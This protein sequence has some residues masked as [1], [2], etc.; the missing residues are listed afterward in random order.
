MKLNKFIISALLA[1]GVQFANAAE[2]PILTEDFEN[3]DV[4]TWNWDIVSIASGNDWR[5][6]DWNGSGVAQMSGFNADADSNDWLVS[7]EIE[8]TS[9]NLEFVYVNF[10]NEID[11]SGPATR[12]LLSTDYAGDVTT[13]TW[14]DLSDEVVWSTDDPADSGKINLTDYVGQNIYLAFHYTS[15]PT[16]A[17]RISI[18]NLNVI[19]TDEDPAVVTEYLETFSGS[20]GEWT[21][22]SLSGESVWEARSFSGNGFAQMSGFGDDDFSNDWLVSPEFDVTDWE[23]PY[24]QFSTAK[25][26]DGDAL[27]VFVTTNYNAEGVEATDWVEITDSFAYSEGGYDSVESGRLDLRSIIGDEDAIRVAFQYTSSEA[28]SALWQVDN[29]LVGRFNPAV[30]LEVNT[31][32]EPHF[33]GLNDGFELWQSVNLSGSRSWEEN[34]RFDGALYTRMSG[35]RDDADSI[36]WLVS[37]TFDMSNWASQTIEFWSATRFDGPVIQVLVSTDFVDNVETATWTDI[38]EQAALSEGDYNWVNS[39]VIDVSDMVTSNATFAF[40]YT[41]DDSGAATWQLDSLNVGGVVPVRP[42]EFTYTT[43]SLEEFSAGFT[44]WS[45]VS[46][47]SDRDWEAGVAVD[48]DY[49]SISGDGGDV[50][51]NDWLVSPTIDTTANDWDTA[52]VQLATAKRNDGE[53]LKLLI[54][55]DYAGDVAA[56]TWTDLS[57]QAGFATRDDDGNLVTTEWS[58]DIY[59][60]IDSGEVDISDFIGGNITVAIQYTSGADAATW[61]VDYVRVV[62]IDDGFS[63]TPAVINRPS[64]GST[65]LIALVG[66]ALVGF[67]KRN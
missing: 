26:F 24:L 29:V 53:N 61:R 63:D 19:N 6:R 32:D 28:G 67:R 5:Y 40:L 45:A 42:T 22:E 14:I 39:T 23:A 9:L 17:T 16:E 27:R 41:S 12:L 46:V 62:E 25:N 56:A 30:I 44:G 7:S 35:F 60:W 54:S 37:P 11:F 65:G 64:S 18:D 43:Y 66:L 34:V 21:E 38:T 8:L 47:A 10:Q 1:A 59:E 50:D 51:S 55:T 4:T 57:E 3:T 48:T 58:G 33:E 31:T 52:F 15:T 2:E 13:A 20:L 49:V 36:D